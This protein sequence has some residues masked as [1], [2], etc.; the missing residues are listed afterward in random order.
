M[1][2]AGDIFDELLDRL[3]DAG[4]PPPRWGRKTGTHG[5]WLNCRLPKGNIERHGD[6]LD[7]A[8]RNILL[9]DL[10]AP[11]KEQAAALESQ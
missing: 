5:V 3:H 9:L 6:T 8:A 4:S 2:G 7:V 1:Y 10:A 11:D